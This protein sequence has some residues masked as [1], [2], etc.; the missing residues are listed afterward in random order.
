LWADCRLRR[1]AIFLAAAKLSL[2]IVPRVVISR[3]LRAASAGEQNE[4]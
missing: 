2:I 4:R 1:R 3:L